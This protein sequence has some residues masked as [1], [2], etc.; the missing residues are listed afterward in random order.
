VL[1]AVLVPAAGTPP[2]AASACGTV[3]GPWRVLDVPDGMRTAPLRLVSASG[4]EGEVLVVS[5]GTSV[6]R[7][8]DAGCSWRLLDVPTQPGRAVVD[9]VAVVEPGIDRVHVLT[10]DANA[11]AADAGRVLT[12]TD[13]GPFELALPGTFTMAS[14]RP[15]CPPYRGCHLVTS[16]ADP[17]RLFLLA[18]PTLQPGQLW[19]SDDGGAS[20]ALVHSM[21]ADPAAERQVAAQGSVGGVLELQPHPTDRDTLVA[22]FGCRSLAR[23]DDGGAT[24]RVV[25]RPGDPARSLVGLAAATPPSGGPQRLVAVEYSRFCN[26]DRVTAVHVSVDAGET[27]RSA[28]IEGN[29]L[30]R[31]AIDAPG[32]VAVV[33]DEDGALHHVDVAAAT[34]ERLASPGDVPVTDVTR[35][36]PEPGAFVAVAPVRPAT[37]PPAP[38]RGCRRCRRWSRAASQRSSRARRTRRHSRRRRRSRS[39]PA[40]GP[41]CR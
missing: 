7:S 22:A 5:D 28:P 31:V 35:R 32:S 30:D 20:F 2:A 39:T 9:L 38:L 26:G 4:V 40:A 27:W 25:D 17:D 23:S 3:E 16:D 11:F 41:T 33:S 1:A 13:G 36:G 8:D 12:S 34:V 29:D 24:W 6:A 19:R 18:M 15:T 14:G 10:G 21:A 37:A